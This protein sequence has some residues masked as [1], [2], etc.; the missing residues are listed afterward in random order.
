[1]FF[2]LDPPSQTLPPQRAP[3]LNH[4]SS[5]TIPR[6]YGPSE[7]LFFVCER[8]RNECEINNAPLRFSL[9]HDD[10]F[11]SY[12]QKVK[13]RLDVER[14]AIVFLVWWGGRDCGFFFFLS[15]VLVYYFECFWI[16]K[17]FFLKS[18]D[19]PLEQDVELMF[20][21]NLLLT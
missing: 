4:H 1:M 9:L 3:F 16:F 11:R 18:W 10:W 13:L 14:G 20:M 7:S 5:R 2:H 8:Y 21:V 12:L 17:N 6:S 15:Q 19:F